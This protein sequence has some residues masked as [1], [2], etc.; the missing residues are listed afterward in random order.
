MA[1]SCHTG[2]ASWFA[3]NHQRRVAG[4][5]VR[6]E[7]PRGSARRARADSVVG[8]EA[9]ED[10]VRRAAARGRPPSVRFV[11]GRAEALPLPDADLDG[12]LLNEV[13]EHV[14]NGGD[15][16]R[17]AA[18]PSPWRPPGQFGPNRSPP[19]EGH[20]CLVA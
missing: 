13:L 8:A 20:G 11:W 4:L 7:I 12:V 15:A 2:S 17:T 1:A 19:T 10:L 6:P 5:L 14:V 3:G 16:V 9:I 18:R